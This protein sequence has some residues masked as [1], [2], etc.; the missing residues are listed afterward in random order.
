MNMPSLK[1]ARPALSIEELTA[2]PEKFLDLTITEMHSI[3]N[4][5]LQ[6]IHA[7]ALSA[8]FTAMVERVPV[9]ALLAEE[10]HIREISD[11]AQAGPLLLSHSVYKSYPLSVLQNGRFDRLT[12]WLD[13]LTAHDLSAS[14]ASACG[15]IRDWYSFL[16][17]STYSRVKH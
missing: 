13:K 2:A 10:Q 14:D 1:F 6:E 16:I 7:R 9:L 12:G 17:P 3:P 5:T 4:G 15:R 8:H 11:I